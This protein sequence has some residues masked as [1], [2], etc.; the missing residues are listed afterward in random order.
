MACLWRYLQRTAVCVSELRKTCSQVGNYHPIYW[1]PRQNKKARKKW[2][3]FLVNLG[4]PSPALD[5]RISGSPGLKIC[6]LQ[7]LS[8]RFSGLWPWTE[9]YIIGFPGSEAFRFRLGYTMGLPQ[10]LAWRWPIVGLLCLYNH[11]SQ[12]PISPLSIPFYL[13]SLS[14]EP[15]LIHIPFTF[16]LYLSLWL[17]I[18]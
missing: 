12:F 17:L 1:G 10:S 11:V 18:P 8:F 4:H 13:S 16:C 9:N 6:D 3:I 5:I 15:W 7:N 14:G 2:I